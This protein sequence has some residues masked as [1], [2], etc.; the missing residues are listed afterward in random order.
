MSTMLFEIDRVRV[1]MRRLE[2]E[3]DV[4]SHI[5]QLLVSSGRDGAGKRL[6]TA[7]KRVLKRA[8][9]RGGVMGNDTP[10]REGRREIRVLAGLELVTI[11]VLQQHGFSVQQI[12]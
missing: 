9:R 3:R 2:F 8:H 1:R 12:G 4:D 10:N 7:T 5:L 11:C 6:Y